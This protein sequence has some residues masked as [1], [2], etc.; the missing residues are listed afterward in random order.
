MASTYAL[1]VRGVNVGGRAAL[2]MADFRAVLGDLGLD[3]V[4]T[5]LRSG[6]AVVTSPKPIS[7]SALAG[8]VERALASE[9]GLTT[10]VLALTHG[11]LAKIVDGSPYPA[12]EQEPT[13]HVVWFLIDKPE[14]PA[15]A[16][17]DLAPFAPEELAVS[18]QVIYLRLPDGQGRSKL[19]PVLQRKLRVPFTARN[20]TTVLALHDLTG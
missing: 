5:Y 20:W 7:A 1:L 11:Q 16:D 13:H 19:I 17:L 12:P 14:G 10:R 4:Q 6:Q 2:K 3:G 8:S 15:V 18:G 9:C